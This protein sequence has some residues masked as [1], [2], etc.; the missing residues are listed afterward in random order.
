MGHSQS[1]SLG[2]AI[3]IVTSIDPISAIKHNQKENIGRDTKKKRRK[4]VEQNGKEIEK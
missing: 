1:G 2:D 3:W 4:Q